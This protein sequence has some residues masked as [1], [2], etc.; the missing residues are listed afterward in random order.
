MDVSE[1]P[2]ERRPDRVMDLRTVVVEQTI[3]TGEELGEEDLVDLVRELDDHRPEDLNRKLLATVAENHGTARGRS[4]ITG[5][6]PQR[7]RSAQ[8]VGSPKDARHGQDAWPAG[9][10]NAKGR[11]AFLAPSAVTHSWEVC[12]GLTGGAVG[13]ALYRP[14]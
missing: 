3:R 14:S 6:A 12:D 10:L 8:T 13:G 2:K 1:D 7:R 9:R 5:S 11:P 4:D